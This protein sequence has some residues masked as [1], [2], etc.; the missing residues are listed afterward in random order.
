MTSWLE[1]IVPT[2]VAA[3]DEV[4]AELIDS[5]AGA[6]SGT[7][8][9][10][11]EVVFWVSVEAG[12][13]ALEQCR[14]VARKLAARGLPIDPNRVRSQPAVPE[15][16][17]RDAWKRYFHVTRLSNRFVVVPS[18]ESYTAEADDVV[19]DLDPGQAFGTGAHA[20]TQ[21][22]LAALDDMQARGAQVRRFCDVGCGSGILSIAAAKL[23]PDSTGVAVDVDPLAIAAT[24]S[25]AS[26]NQVQD[27]IAASTTAAGSIDG[28]FEL[29]VAN[30]QAHV[31]T[32]LLDDIVA[33]VAEDGTL[34]LSGLLTSQA[35]DV[36]DRYQQRGFEPAE[37]TTSS[38]DPEWTSAVLRRST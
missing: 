35:G 4:A 12:E 16:E 32:A 20:S 8:V 10:G 25:N 38:R 34:M 7:Q 24:S 30:I 5:V 1:V 36:A 17:W 2:S 37:L 13:E 22:L 21:L 9:R 11:D 15:E 26:N 18:W 6:Q 29:V 33:L 27:R 23:W 14:A 3:A 28:R 31:L 19:L